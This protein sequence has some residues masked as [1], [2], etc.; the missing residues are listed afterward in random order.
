MWNKKYVISDPL[1]LSCK[2]RSTE[3]WVGLISMAPKTC[4]PFEIMANDLASSKQS[5]VLGANEDWVGP[6]PHVQT[7]GH[8]WETKPRGTCICL[9]AAAMHLN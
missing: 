1:H 8:V 4:M 7:L 3:K 2:V 9:S 5:H 6:S